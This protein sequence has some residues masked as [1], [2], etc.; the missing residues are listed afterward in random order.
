MKKGIRFFWV[1][2]L[3]GV[4][5]S[6]CSIDRDEDGKIEI[7]TTDEYLTG[8]LKLMYTCDTTTELHL[9]DDSVGKAQL[10]N[11]MSSLNW[12]S[13]NS[14]WLQNKEDDLLEVG[15]SYDDGFVARYVDYD[16]SGI[17]VEELVSFYPIRTPDVL[18]TI[19]LYGYDKPNMVK[20]AYF[21]KKSD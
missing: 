10:A 5:F 7:Q 2:F 21:Q 11:F 16:S 18:S 20:T 13:F 8:S 14:V 9:I 19:I 12:H 6:C 1:W 4:T 3:I 17:L 15:G